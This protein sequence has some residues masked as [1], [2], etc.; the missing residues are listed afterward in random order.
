M[1]KEFVTQLLTINPEQRWTY[2]E[3]LDNLVRL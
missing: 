2:K 3:V 1:F